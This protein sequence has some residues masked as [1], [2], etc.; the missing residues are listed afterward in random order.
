[1]TLFTFYFKLSSLVFKTTHF[2]AAH[3][4][5]E[6]LLVDDSN[7]KCEINNKRHLSGGR[8]VQNKSRFLKQKKIQMQI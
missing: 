8:E 1:M 5:L 6:H 4:I 3:N 7:S 2:F